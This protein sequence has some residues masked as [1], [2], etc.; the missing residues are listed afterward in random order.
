M[1]R[2]EKQD[3][4]RLLELLDE[5]L[6]KDNAL[7]EVYLVGGAVMCLVLGAR[8]STRDVDAFFKPTRVIRQ[9]AARVAARARVPDNW[10]NDSVK[11]FLSPRGDYQPTWSSTTC[12]SLSPI[13]VTFSR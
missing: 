6:A 2:L 5:E 11:G 4:Q 7:G 12:G 8:D 3:I 13:R 10:L 1:S 9:A